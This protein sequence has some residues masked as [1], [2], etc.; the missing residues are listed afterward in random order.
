M[1]QTK[2]STISNDQLLDSSITNTE[3][4]RQAIMGSDPTILS[5]IYKQETNI[6][7][8]QRNL[9]QKIATAVDQLLA[10]R[11]EFKASM[12]VTPQT[13][14]TALEDFFGNAN[15]L[16]LCEDI[17]EVVDMYCYL[18]DLKRVG[19]RLTTLDRAMC[20]RFHVDKVPCRL[21][22]TYQGIATEWLPHQ[23]VNREKLGQGSDG[24][25][26]HQSGLFTH[27][28]NIQQLTCG[29]IALLK[30]ERWEGNENA[31]LVHRSPMLNSDQTRLL[32]TLD[33]IN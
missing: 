25:P 30:G 27:E 32:L 21:L 1:L 17:A 10:A 13:T 16:D 8:W 26:D 5:D 31:G 14:I 33:F 4:V 24:L 19:L 3:K 12:T 2:T 29:D 20:P 7:V 22:T 15:Q 11:A 9:S 28:D 23:V 18:F 6:V